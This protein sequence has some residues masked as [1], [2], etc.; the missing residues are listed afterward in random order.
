M[1][2]LDT[3]ALVR[4]LVRDDEKQ[5]QAVRRIIS[6]AEGSGTSL[7]VSLLVLLETVWVLGS[8]YGFDRDTI[9]RA[10]DAITALRGLELED[11][12]SVCELCQ[13]AGTQPAGIPDLL[14]GI[15][16][17]SRGCEN[18]LTFDQKAAKTK[19]FKLIGP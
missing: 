8:T 6:E 5:A 14:I 13:V 10:L 4:F 7:F 12:E 9:V 3:N 2:A 11:R 1:N 15:V 16:A 17:R 18:V 19:Y